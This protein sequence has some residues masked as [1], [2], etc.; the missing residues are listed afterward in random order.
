MTSFFFPP[1]QSD[2]PSFDGILQTVAPA[3][4]KEMLTFEKQRLCITLRYLATG[5][6]YKDLKFIKVISKA[7]G[8]VVLE[9]CLLFSRQTDRL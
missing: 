1:V 7:I 2:D 8:I 3:V 6:N 4:A 9:T 5:S